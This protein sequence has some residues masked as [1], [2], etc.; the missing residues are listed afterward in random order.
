MFNFHYECK[1]YF[2]LSF[3]WWSITTNNWDNEHLS[4]M[5]ML[6]FS[7]DRVKTFQYNFSKSTRWHT[8]AGGK[9]HCVSHEEWE[10]RAPLSI[11]M[12]TS[13]FPS[14]VNEANNSHKELEPW[15]WKR[16]KPNQ[17]Y[18][19]GCFSVYQKWSEHQ[20]YTN[21]LRQIFSALKLPTWFYITANLFSGF[22]ICTVWLS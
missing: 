9:S 18:Y 12:N 19:I 16:N 17:R 13:N 2:S 11:S 10:L 20:C 4:A 7:N 14:P 6:R 1:L 15:N 5:A 22:V 3:N 8:K 21:L